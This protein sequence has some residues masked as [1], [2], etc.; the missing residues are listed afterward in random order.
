MSRSRRSAK[1]VLV[2]T[3]NVVLPDLRGTAR[4]AEISMVEKIKDLPAKL[5]YLVLADLGALDN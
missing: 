4:L 5:D 1:R 3:P 2:I